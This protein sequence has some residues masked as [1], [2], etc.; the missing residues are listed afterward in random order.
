MKNLQ[1]ERFEILEPGMKYAKVRQLDVGP[2]APE[3]LYNYRDLF[4]IETNERPNE[5]IN[6]IVN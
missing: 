5:G 2:N 4:P 1:G 6:D 3:P